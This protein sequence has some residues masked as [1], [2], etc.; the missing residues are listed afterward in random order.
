MN[1]RQW[2][3]D[4]MRWRRM[5]EQMNAFVLAHTEKTCNSCTSQTGYPYA[6]GWGEP[7]RWNCP[8]FRGKADEE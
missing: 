8:F 6:P 4:A 3:K 1:K 7:V 2:K 5:F